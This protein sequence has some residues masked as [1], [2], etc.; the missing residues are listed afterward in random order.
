HDR[1]TFKIVNELK[2]MGGNPLNNINFPKKLKLF[3][4]HYSP[5]PSTIE[6]DLHDEQRYLAEKTGCLIFEEGEGIG[7]QLAIESFINIS[8]LAISVDTHVCTVGALG[9]LGLR[10]PFNV[11][12][13]VLNRGFFKYYLPE[14]IQVR[15][16]GKLQDLCCGNDVIMH[17]S[18]LGEEKFHNSIIEFTGQGVNNLTIED[19][20]TIA[21]LA[22]DIHARGVIF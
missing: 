20:I 13:E 16:T 22:Y 15:L 4:D 2:S 5:P 21:N 18:K 7:H 9:A 6:V 11:I 12:G 10:T 17:L 14:I 3:M 8:D 1:N 19:R